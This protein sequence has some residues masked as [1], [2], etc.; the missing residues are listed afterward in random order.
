MQTNFRPKQLTAEDIKNGCINLYGS[1]NTDTQ[2]CIMNEELRQGL[3]ILEDYQKSI[4]I[5]GSARTPETD[6]YYQSAVRIGSGAVKLGKAVITG[7]GPGIMEA[8]NRG[9]M[10]AGG[11]SLG[12]TIVLP[13]EQSTNPYVTVDIPFYFF[14]TRKTAMRYASQVYLFFPGGY[15]TL[16]ELMETLTLIQTGKIDKVPVVL[17]GAEFWQPLDQFIR[18]DLVNE[19]MISEMDPSLYI[20][21]DDEQQ[22]LEIIKTAPERVMK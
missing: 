4:T 20:I 18:Q 2:I 17:V 12:M 11:D 5:F 19:A 6:P 1:D 13:H 7:G 9:A 21:T 22:I 3:T 14:F 16:D 15:G 8:G 10:D